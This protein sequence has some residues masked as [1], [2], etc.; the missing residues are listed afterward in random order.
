MRWTLKRVCRA[1]LGVALAGWLLPDLRAIESTWEYSVQV[2][3]S[4]QSVPAQVTLTW[5]Q[6]SIAVPE[7]YTVYRKDAQATSWGTGTLLAGAD[8]SYVDTNV[9]VGAIYE[10][11]I[12]KT[13]STY[14]GYGYVE[15]GIDVPLAERRGAV[16]LIVDNTYAADLVV[17]LDRLRQ[18]L[19]GDGWT[20][21]RHDVARTETVP[22]VK[23]LIQGDYSS[24][25][26]E[27][28]AVFLFGHVPVPYAG[29]IV[30]DDHDPEHHGAWPA[31]VYYGDMTGLWTDILVNT[32]GATESRNW[33]V[34]GDGKFDP[35]SPPGSVDL[36]VGRVDLA[37]LPGQTTWNGPATFPGE[38]DLLRQYLNKDHG[39]RHKLI[40]PPRRGL[41]YDGLG[42]RDG[43]AYA[44]SAY[45][46]FAP[47][48]D[49][50]NVVTLTN[51]GT[52][53]ATL[54]TNCYLWAYGAGGGAYNSI[55]GIG[56]NGIYYSGYST[57]IVA[58]DAQVVFA[59][60]FGS[61]LGDWDSP[62]NIMRSILATPTYGLTCVWSGAPH[63]FLH[64]MGLGETIGYCAR[65][66]QNNGPNGL[67]QNETN[68]AAGGIH[69]ALMGDPT[70]R[71]H[72]V[73]LPSAL[74]G[75]VVTN[76]VL[77]NWA[78]SSDTVL[79][80]YVYR[81]NS[82]DGPF[83]RL[84]DS[85][86]DNTSY[87]DDSAASGVYTYMVRAVKL[88]GTPS[89]TYF[90]ASQG[91]FLEVTVDSSASSNTVVWVD[92]SVPTGAVPDADGG[93][94]WTWVS[95]DPPPWC[96]GVASQSSL[97]A[98]L[99]E[100]Y[101]HDATTTLAIGTGDTLF[102]YVYLDSTNPP[103][104]IMLQWN[105]GSWDHR[106]YWG[107]D[108]ITYGVD[109]TAGR[110]YLGPLPPVGQWV[111]L[112]VAASVVGLEGSKLNGMSFTLFDGRA[113]WDCAGKSSGS[114]SGANAPFVAITA[115]GNDASI[116]GSA[117]TVSATAT[118]SLGVL[119]V[120]FKLDDANLGPEVATPP[121]V[122]SW[123]TTTLANGPH[124]LTAVM[125]DAAG[126]QATSSVVSVVVSNAAGS[127][128]VWVDES[129]PDGA[130]PGADGG[131]GWNWIS[132][133]PAPYSGLLASQSNLAAGLH[134]HYFFAVSTP[135]IV[136]TGDVLFAYVYL[137]PDNV[138]S[139]VMLQWNDGSWEHRAYW[140][141]DAITYG[142]DRT[143][144]RSYMGPLPAAGQWV[145][146]EVPASLVGL[147]GRAING[148]AFSLFDGRAVWDY[149]G[150]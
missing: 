87:T 30:P 114:T 32:T 69:V 119:G 28:K 133:N 24:D 16:V 88:E 101:F 118:D 31:D 138:P 74:I 13:A 71:M 53:I 8:T 148:M 26:A 58:A 11:Q 83:T 96:G 85:L 139:E 150:K 62:D 22:N 23:A 144:G 99:H 41:V 7:S 5:P 143:A 112:A 91:I 79:G 3:A 90:N 60:L 135:L 92:D 128:V 61:W 18:D 43:E 82:P 134:E 54:Q 27:V 2:T 146:L 67:Y 102:A 77:L 123:D 106:A 122:I 108:L 132:S 10:Y 40:D 124:A 95:N 130:V 120:Q 98:G 42:V 117:V 15:A 44:A 38:L 113:T 89:G 121:F 140:G 25:P 103:S 76:G 72:P 14:T 80:Y 20:V 97:G 81:A 4:V 49:P 6:D 73:G 126:Q 65:L 111:R 93:D 136:N 17:E 125:R 107:A 59:M 109:G 21:L 47:L 94:A 137:D 9:S 147:E 34:P 131:D 66:T 51:Q 12:V 84:T 50:A 149:A 64:P 55:A 57:D 116:S 70:L 110:Y 46:A 52:W 100:H 142:A 115:P 63:W 86:I 29:N 105:D 75:T 1:V 48:L 19:V 104:E 45:R 35:S 145:R 129:L 78:A 33:N 141:T 56:T 127:A 36:E 37:N 68:P 39:F